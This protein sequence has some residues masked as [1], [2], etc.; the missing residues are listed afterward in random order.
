AIAAIVLSFKPLMNMIKSIGKVLVEFLRPI[1]DIITVLLAPVLGM[2][3]GLLKIFMVAM[4]P[5]RKAAYKLMRGSME[6]MRDAIQGGDVSKFG[7]GILKSLLAVETL[8]IGLIVSLQKMFMQLMKLQFSFMWSIA[9]FLLKGVVLAIAGLASIFSKTIGK[10]IAGIGGA[11]AG[12]GDVMLE[13][14]FEFLDAAMEKGIDMAK[15]AII[16]QASAL[17]IDLSKDLVQ[18][19]KDVSWLDIGLQLYEGVAGVFRGVGAYVSGIMGGEFDE[20]F[21]EKTLSEIFDKIA[22]V[23]GD[24]LEAAVKE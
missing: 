22:Q 11:L 2:L 13:N 21:S 12:G 6:D 4:L 9:K 14:Y 17:G 10:R 5:F 7:T 24:T 19:M 20:A 15:G 18:T 1:S 3:R 8:T 23:S 16:V